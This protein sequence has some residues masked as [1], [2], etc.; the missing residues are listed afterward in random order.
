MCKLAMDSRA[1]GKILANVLV[2]IT[3]ESAAAMSVH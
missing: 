3:K 1:A 2:E